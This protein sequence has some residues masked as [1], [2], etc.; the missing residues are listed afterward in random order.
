[1]AEVES[2][3]LGGLF[4]PALADDGAILN[5]T[6]LIVVSQWRRRG[7]ARALVRELCRQWPNAEKNWASDPSAGDRV[8][9]VQTTGLCGPGEACPRGLDALICTCHVTM[10]RKDTNNPR[11]V[12]GMT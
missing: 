3:I 2:N 8:R 4:A 7:V 11:S 1:M 10:Y 6:E 12:P 9:G 5:V